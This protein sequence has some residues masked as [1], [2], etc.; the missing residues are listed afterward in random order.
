MTGAAGARENAYDLLGK[1]LAPFV[2]LLTAKNAGRAL[3][4]D[5]SVVEMTGLP[6]ENAGLRVNLSME[7]PDK[8]RL[9]A[10]VLGADSAVCR[11]GQQLWAAPGAAIGALLNQLPTSAAPAKPEGRLEDFVLQL[12]EN[13][14][15][16]LPALFQVTDEGDE[17]VNGESCRVLDLTLI[18]ELARSAGEGDWSARIWVRSGGKLAKLELLKPHWHVTVAFDRLDF[19]GPL[20]A[21]TWQPPADQ[22]ADV[23]RL[24]A[25]KFKQ[26]LSFIGLT[27]R[28][29][30]NA[31]SLPVPKSTN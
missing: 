9:R 15:A 5:V 14:L 12:P 30:G 23:L 10:K 13:Q 25:A 31:P 2:N 4:A 29:E 22:A 24:D 6:A 18:P 7:N 3:S 20:P 17:S 11:N 28:L 27:P 8:L 26:L 21:G 1:T 16:F 19:T